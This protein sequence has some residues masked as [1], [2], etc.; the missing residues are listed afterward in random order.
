MYLKIMLGVEKQ[1][2]HVPRL[3]V[4]IH[5]LQTHNVL[6]P[7]LPENLRACG[8]YEIAGFVLHRIAGHYFKAHRKRCP[9]MVWDTHPGPHTDISLHDES[10]SPSFSVPFI[11][12]S[13]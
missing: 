9:C 1:Q 11:F 2:P 3:G 6:V 10:E 4:E 12:F 13:A 7:E 5:F 8:Q